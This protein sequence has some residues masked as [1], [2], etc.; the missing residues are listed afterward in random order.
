MGSNLV[1]A[2]IGSDLRY[3]AA[4]IVSDPA[5]QFAA[6]EV[7]ADSDERGGQPLLSRLELVPIE[8]T[9]RSRHFRKIS[10]KSASPGRTIHP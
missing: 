6:T 8:L 9:T 10:A 3:G 2:A 1:A 5:A 4:W 7:R